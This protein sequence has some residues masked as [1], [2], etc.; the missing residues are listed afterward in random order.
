[1]APPLAPLAPNPPKVD[2]VESVVVSDTAKNGPSFT[3][4]QKDATGGSQR[5]AAPRQLLVK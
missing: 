1:M 2:C 5:Q 4:G 3:G